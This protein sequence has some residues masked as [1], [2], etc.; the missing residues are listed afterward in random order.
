MNSKKHSSDIDRDYVLR[1][2]HTLADPAAREGM[3]RFGV[4]T[5]RALGIKI[6][7]LRNLAKE[8]KKNHPLAGELW[9]TGIHEARILAAYISDPL[10]VTQQQMEDWV[11]DFNSWDLCDQVCGN[12]FDKTPYAWTKAIEWA[13]REEEYVKRAGF[14]LMASLAVHDKRTNDKEF[15]K[16]LPLII[17]EC[18]DERNFVKKAVNWALR[19][20][21]KRSPLLKKH[22]MEVAEN[23]LQST[24]A[25]AR[26]VASDA[27]KELKTKE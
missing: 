26:W 17:G 19:Q 16:F 3:R 2:L 1:Q 5:D 22:S 25:S 27:L 15:L 4:S 14:V 6:P 23:M 20:I 11:K 8:I 9:A 7:A 18:E 12:L 24:S 13:K 10:L 21:G